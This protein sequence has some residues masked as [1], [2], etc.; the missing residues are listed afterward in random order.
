[1]LVHHCLH[2]QQAD[3]P[4]VHSTSSVIELMLGW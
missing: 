2:P 3:A 1:M 4:L